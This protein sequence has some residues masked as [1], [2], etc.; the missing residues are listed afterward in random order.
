MFATIS[1]IVAFSLSAIGMIV[2]TIYF[3]RVRIGK[4][5]ITTFWWFPLFFAI[6]ILAFRFVDVSAFIDSLL[7]K[8]N[9][10]PLEIL[11]LFLSMSF[12]SIV[13]DEVGFFERLAYIASKK[14][15]KSQIALFFILYALISLLTIFTSNDIIIITFTPFI[16][17]F[18]KNAKINPIPYLIMEFVAANTWSL[19]FIIGNPTNIYLASSQGI[20]FISYFKIMYLP[21]IFGG[22]TS[23]GLLF[24]LF[25][26]S[27][28]KPIV[29]TAN[30]EPRIKDKI[31]LIISLSFLSITIILMAIASFIQISMWIICAIAACALVLFLL[32]YSI[33]KHQAII[34]TGHSLKRI[35]YDII[36][37]I[38][39]MFLIVFSLQY[40]GI[41][42]MLVNLFSN[43]YPI[44]TYGTSGFLLCNIINNIPMS[45]LYSSLIS[46]TGNTTLIYQQIYASIIA[47]NIGA[48]LTP[49]G[50]LAGIMWSSIL[51][52]HD[53]KMTY[54]KFILYGVMISIPTLAMSLLG[55]FIVLH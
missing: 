17:F 23:L 26:K 18:S 14:A 36:P 30:E 35:P 38:L 16:I 15:G 27:L 12:L 53:V 9:I 41:S 5:T 40:N 54:P 32:I 10:N 31:I 11:A 50:A 20:D 47:S 3:P 45:V 44:L 55:L 13:L 7:A 22:L 8:G 37:F 33:F 4:V 34:T 39:S 21:T 46:Q 51:K 28:K 52:N 43:N 19:L 2:S 24:L 6:L 49:V 25:H 42:S 29:I 1:V 48:F